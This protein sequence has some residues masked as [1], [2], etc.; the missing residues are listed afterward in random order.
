MNLLKP[1]NGGLKK[2]MR[3][4]VHPWGGVDSSNP[5]HQR[6]WWLHHHGGGVSFCAFCVVSDL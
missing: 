4:A 5:C 1:N 3:K 6:G 2:S